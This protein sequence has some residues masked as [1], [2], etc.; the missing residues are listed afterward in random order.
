MIPGVSPLNL[1][2]Q[3]VNLNCC[4]HSSCSKQGLNQVV[5]SVNRLKRSKTCTMGLSELFAVRF[6]FQCFTTA[7]AL[8][9][10]FLNISSNRFTAFQ[11]D[12]QPVTGTVFH[13]AV[14]SVFVTSLFP[15]FFKRLFNVFSINFVHRDHRLC[16]FFRFFQFFQFLPREST[17]DRSLHHWYVF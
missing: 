10:R 11:I 9:L 7:G 17:L 4:L 16:Q 14:S 5:A 6:Q 1:T 13:L 2:N 15:R 8:Q 3:A 12:E